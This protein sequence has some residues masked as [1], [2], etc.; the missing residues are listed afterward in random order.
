M[1]TLTETRQEKNL[2]TKT[3]YLKG[4]VKVSEITE[5]HHK[6]YVESKSFFK[7]IGGREHHVKGYTRKGYKVVRIVSH[8]PDAKIKVTRKFDF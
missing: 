1:I 2:N 6:N 8:S 5:E 4:V 3:T 7:N